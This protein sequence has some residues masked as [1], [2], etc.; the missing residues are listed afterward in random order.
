MF[1]NTFPLN[2]EVNVRCGSKEPQLHAHGFPGTGMAGK[3]VAGRRVA[4]LLLNGASCIF[5]DVTMR[6]LEAPE[7]A[8][9]MMTHRGSSNLSVRARQLAGSNKQKW[10]EAA[11]GQLE[12]EMCLAEGLRGDPPMHLSPVQRDPAG[13]DF[14]DLFDSSSDDAED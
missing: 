7:L 5:F 11:R 12:Q 6:L 10:H 3:V 14:G 9:V 13:I 1:C 2:N 4:E 8:R